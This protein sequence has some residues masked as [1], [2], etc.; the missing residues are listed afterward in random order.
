MD[1]LVAFVRA[2]LDEDERIAQGADRNPP[3]GST[4]WTPAALQ[5]TWDARVDEHVA[6][7]NPARVLREVEAKRRILG[8][9]FESFLPNGIPLGTCTTCDNYAMPCPTLRLLALPYADDPDYR[10][11]WAA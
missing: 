2:R 7:H 3:N 4:S 6:R 9:H 10:P 1:D 11:E 8:E 5:T